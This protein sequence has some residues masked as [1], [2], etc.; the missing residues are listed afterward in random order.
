MLVDKS[1]SKDSKLMISK[2]AIEANH[3]LNI[4]ANI[5]MKNG[6]SYKCGETTVGR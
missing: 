5:K 4:D 6:V 2:K 1:K 3:F